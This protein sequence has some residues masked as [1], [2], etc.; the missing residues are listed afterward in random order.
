MGDTV[1]IGAVLLRLADS[2]DEPMDG[3]SALAAPEE[4]GAHTRL[5]A[6]PV[7]RRAAADL[8]VA[9]ET[10][11]GTGPRG[12]V[13]LVDVRNAAA[14]LDVPAS[15]EP[16]EELTPLR[17][18]IARRMTMSQRIPHYQLVRDVDASHLIAQKEA[19]AAGTG[20]PAESTTCSCRRSPR[21]WCATPR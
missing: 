20:A 19:Q 11:R 4:R 18:A 14:S 10:V 3:A 21:P 6:A 7:A 15:D 8:G 2:V 17:R 1:P 12:R 9:L 5:R 16:V 13:T